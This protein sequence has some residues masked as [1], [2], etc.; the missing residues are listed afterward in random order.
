MT[1]VRAYCVGRPVDVQIKPRPVSPL[2][3]ACP[4]CGAQPGKECLEVGTAVVLYAGHA[5]RRR[6]AA[7]RDGGA[8]A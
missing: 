6:S 1:L 3:V 8:R 5:S 2:S 7:Q 4:S